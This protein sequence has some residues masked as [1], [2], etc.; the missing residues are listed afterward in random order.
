MRVRIATRA[1]NA[2]A[3]AL[4]PFSEV[5]EL[6]TSALS[7]RLWSSTQRLIQEPTES[8]KLTD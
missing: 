1:H 7:N 5:P 8:A 2:Q 4:V 6:V 3:S